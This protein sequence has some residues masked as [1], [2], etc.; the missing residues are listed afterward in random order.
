MV[1][2]H[3]IGMNNVSHIQVYAATIS[4]ILQIDVEIQVHFLSVIYDSYY[5]VKHDQIKDLRVL[6]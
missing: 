1:F 3:M 4:L 5:P 6:D 2:C